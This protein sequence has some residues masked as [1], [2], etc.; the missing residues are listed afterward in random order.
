MHRGIMGT[1]FFCSFHN[2]LQWQ[3]ETSNTASL[4]TVEQISLWLWSVL[5]GTIFYW[6]W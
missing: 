3:H 2:T 1:H 5:M 4:K 6:L